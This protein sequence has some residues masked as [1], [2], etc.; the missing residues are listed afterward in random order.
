MNVLLNEKLRGEVS[1]DETDEVGRDQIIEGF[2]SQD[3]EFGFGPK[4]N[5]D[6]LKGLGQGS[7]KDKLVF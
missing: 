1:K 4:G 6:P 3:K 5:W 2:I 7:N